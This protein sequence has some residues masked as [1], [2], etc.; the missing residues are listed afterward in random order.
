MTEPR[1]ATLDIAKGLGILLVV[2]GHNDWVIAHPLLRNAIYTFHVPLFIF[3]AGIFFKPERP[4]GP[5]LAS[6]ADGVLKPYFVALLGLVAFQGLFRGGINIGRIQGVLYGTG[7][8]IDWPPLWFLPY[9]FLMTLFAWL[10]WRVARLERA[11]PWHRAAALLVLLAAGVAII[12]AEHAS[13]LRLLDLP[14]GKVGLPWSLDLLPLGGCYFLLGRCCRDAV[15]HTQWRPAAALLALLAF[16]LLFG[17]TGATLDFNERTY[18]NLAASTAS[19]LLGTFLVLQFAAAVQRWS[20]ATRA[21]RYV[22]E[23]TLILLLLHGVVQVRVLEKLDGRFPAGAGSATHGMLAFAAAVLV[24]LVVGEV[25]ARIPPLGVLV[26]P[27]RK[28]L[29]AG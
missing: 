13:A 8:T 9:L 3:L 28:A 24:P 6:R 1:N 4:L 25:L 29:R 18:D 26:L 19:A 2:F 21:L 14:L 10:Y 22:G 27:R 17:Y 12:R 11:S 7:A 23:S 16:A 5:M 15:L 20:L